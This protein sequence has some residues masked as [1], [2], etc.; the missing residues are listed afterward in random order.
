M[1]VVA[2]VLPAMTFRNIGRYGNRGSLNLARKTEG[3][4]LRQEP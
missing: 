4:I 3:F 1:K 2:K